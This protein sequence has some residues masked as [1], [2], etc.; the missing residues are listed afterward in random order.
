V[1]GAWMAALSW[2]ALRAEPQ[3]SISETAS[4]VEAQD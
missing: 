3:G 1:F 4:S 2:G